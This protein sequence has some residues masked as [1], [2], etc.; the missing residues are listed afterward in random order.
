MLPCESRQPI[1]VEQV[2]VKE[3]RITDTR[4]KEAIQKA[5]K[6][7]RREVNVWIKL[8]HAHILTL[9]GTVSGFGPLPALVSTWMQNGAL[10]GYLERTSL[11]T[12]Q[13]LK[14]LKQVVDGLK[15]LHEQ[16][17]IHGDLTSKNVLIDRDGNAFLADFGLSLA[18]AESDKS[19]YQS[20]STGAVR[21]SAPEL[22][23]SANSESILD[24]SNGPIPKPNSQSD[25]FSLGCI[26]LYVFSGKPPFWWIESV[27]Q[28]FGA[29]YHHVEPYRLDSSVTVSDQHL[30]FMWKC[31]SANPE[32]RPSAGDAASF[33]ET[34]LASV[35]SPLSD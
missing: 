28:V 8:R 29:Q 12:E 7:L 27:T 17:V 26:M 24:D 9:H 4:N 2:A 32:D 23:N 14:L 5:T 15:Y 10:N 20:Y 16:G 3:I 19:Y 31:W 33:V 18:L 11:T 22:I 30:D 35:P 1:S 6:R 21:W 13:K 25:V 34:E